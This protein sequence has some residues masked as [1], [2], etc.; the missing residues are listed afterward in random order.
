[1]LLLLATI[2]K[3]NAK[4]QDYY[5]PQIYEWIYLCKNI[6]LAVDCTISLVGENFEI[7]QD[8]SEQAKI[9][10]PEDEDFNMISF[11]RNI[12]CSKSRYSDPNPLR[13]MRAICTY[14]EMGVF[15]CQ[16]SL[17]RL[18][19]QS[20]EVF[21]AFFMKTEVSNGRFYAYPTLGNGS[22]EKMELAEFYDDPDV[23]PHLKNYLIQQ[24]FF[25]SDLS[26]TRNMLWKKQFEVMYPAEEIFEF[27]FMD[28]VPSDVRAGFCQMATYLYIDQEPLVRKEYPQM[29]R[30]LED[31]NR[32][33]RQE[34]DN[35]EGFEYRTLMP[36]IVDKLIEYLD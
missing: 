25:V 26:M 9:V 10:Q 30:I 14:A 18:L 7:I 32:R 4:V 28:R 2:C 5:Y 17:H 27:C 23:P 31:P 35:Y 8:F 6:K 13:F 20:Q 1:V 36:T 12:S 16:E 19:N 21:Y 29:C 33:S 11:Y 34:L 24:I 22:E 3:G 15:P